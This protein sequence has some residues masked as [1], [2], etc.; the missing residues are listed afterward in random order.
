M[1]FVTSKCCRNRVCRKIWKFHTAKVFNKI[2]RTQDKFGN[3]DMI[4]IPK[5][6]ITL[7]EGLCLIKPDETSLIII[8]FLP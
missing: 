1:L 7:P 8:I 3:T 4:K 2:I 5:L 6:V